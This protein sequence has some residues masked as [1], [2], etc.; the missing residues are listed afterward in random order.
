MIAQVHNKEIRIRYQE[1]NLEEQ[2]KK[3]ENDI[4]LAGKEA[5]MKADLAEEA[6][7]PKVA[8]VERE[9]WKAGG[10]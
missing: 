5:K 6:H 3:L 1:N 8:E 4:E 2:R 7:R 10:L 9:R